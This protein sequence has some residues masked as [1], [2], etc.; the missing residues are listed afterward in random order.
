MQLCIL[1]RDIECTLTSQKGKGGVN[2]TRKC[3]L[4]VDTVRAFVLESI[5][6]SVSS[7]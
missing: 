5:L 4:A 6:L 1:Y 7:E 2:V 3:I